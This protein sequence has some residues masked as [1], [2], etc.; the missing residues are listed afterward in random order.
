MVP[1]SRLGQP[2]SGVTGPLSPSRVRRVA[3]PRPGN[4]RPRG[5]PGAA[6]DATAGRPRPAL[7]P[8]CRVVALGRSWGCHTWTRP[9]SQPAHWLGIIPETCP[10]GEGMHLLSRCSASPVGIAVVLVGRTGPFSRDPAATAVVDP[11]CRHRCRHG[12]RRLRTRSASSRSVTRFADPCTARVFTGASRR[13]KRGPWTPGAIGRGSTRP[14]GALT[15]VIRVRSLYPGDRDHR[16]AYR[17]AAGA[18]HRLLGE[19]GP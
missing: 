1:C 11:G 5:D 3:S 14:G 18:D 19:E 17:R 16:S 2:R 15:D 13:L 4:A 10:P 12:A 9:P 6:L 8:G 7:R